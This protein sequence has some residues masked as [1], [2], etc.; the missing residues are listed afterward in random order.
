[1]DNKKSLGFDLI[2]IAKAFHLVA[3]KNCEHLNEWMAASYQLSSLEE[4]ILHDLHI[5]ISNSIN[6]M[7]EEELKARVVGILFY[8]A[9]IDVD[10]RI[11]VFYERPMSATIHGIPMAVICDCM[12]ATPIMNLPEMPYFFLQEFK[13]SK[14]EKKDP[15]AQ[16]LVAMLIAQN[17]NADNKPIYGCFLLGSSWHFTTLIGEHYCISRKYEASNVSDLAQIFFSL[18][19]LKEL[20][21]NR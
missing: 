16:M 19:K 1:M 20:I 9:K 10:D 15:E 7:N 18:K 2:S 4:N 8:G 11:R 13:K 5:D 3:K 17:Q 21:M 6:A 12:V 14:G